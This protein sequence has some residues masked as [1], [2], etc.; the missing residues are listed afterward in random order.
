MFVPLRMATDARGLEFITDL[1][2]SID[3]VARRALYEAMGDDEAMV[4]KRLEE[5]PADTGI[6]VGDETRLRQ[7]ITNLARCVVPI[8]LL[9]RALKLPRSNACKF[10]P[11]GGT[12]RISTRLVLPSAPAR[13]DS[14][15][16]TETLDIPLHHDA[17]K[18][19]ELEID[20]DAC[21]E[22]EQDADASDASHTADSAS[23]REDP[24][25]PAPVPPLAPTS[26]VA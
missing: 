6:V 8:L 17:C 18:E 10:T 12:L 14:A 25:T 7:I 1:D 20:M 16:T 24:L 21:N 3:A 5:H 11:A 23:A 15:R 2:E 13:E 22:K 26:I 19:A 9:R 4:R